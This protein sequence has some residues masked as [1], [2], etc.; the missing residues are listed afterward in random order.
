MYRYRNGD[1]K[2]P[3]KLVR[4][5]TQLNRTG[6]PVY[7]T[8]D[9]SLTYSSVPVT[10]TSR[11]WDQIYTRAQYIA[12]RTN[13]TLQTTYASRSFFRQELSKVVVNTHAPEALYL[14]S[15]QLVRGTRRATTEFGYWG[16]QASSVW[17]PLRDL[18]ALNQAKIQALVKAAEVRSMLLVDFAEAK[19]TQDMIAD[20]VKQLAT[21][22]SHVTSFRFSK[23]G[24][25]LG[26]KSRDVKRA[27][28]R[29][30]RHAPRSLKRASSFWLEVRYGWLPLVYS[31]QDAAAHLGWLMGNPKLQN[32]TLRSHAR[33]SDER[34]TESFDSAG[35]ADGYLFE[36]TRKTLDRTE[37]TIKYWVK[38]VPSSYEL[39]QLNNAGFVNLAEVAWELTRLSWVVDWFVPIGDWISSFSSLVGLSVTDAGYSVARE[40][41]TSVTFLGPNVRGLPSGG[42]YTVSGCDDEIR[43]ESYEYTRYSK[44]QLDQLLG[45]VYPSFPPVK[46]KLNAKR[47]VDAFSLLIQAGHSALRLR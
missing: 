21:A 24:K 10:T 14:Y 34:L 25:V 16:T 4:Q 33:Y 45:G 30:G 47:F 35:T 13:G 31:I 28:R 5:V 17:S 6:S 36:V 23:A 37:N 18:N 12:A 39:H 26:L 38:V 41:T 19:K 43:R 32:R 42:G 46:I 7:E 15:G 22:L 1:V 8:A 27:I 44:T 3:V 2:L 29:A 9:N 40:T 11:T 20:R